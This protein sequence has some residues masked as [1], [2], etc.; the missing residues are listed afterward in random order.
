MCA[1]C[2]SGGMLAMLE[3]ISFMLLRRI[4]WASLG[5]ALSMTASMPSVPGAPLQA[6][7]MVVANSCL[8]MGTVREAMSMAGISCAQA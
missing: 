3:R 7:F 4:V 5:A 8:D 2:H 1:V 6:A